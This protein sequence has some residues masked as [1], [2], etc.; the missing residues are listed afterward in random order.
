MLTKDKLIGVRDQNGIRPLC[1]GTIGNSYVIASES[2]A[3]DA[4]GAD[5]LRD[6][7]PGEIVIID[8]NGL[9]SINFA[10]K[11]KNA[12]CSFEYIYFARPDSTIDGIN[13]YTSRVAAGEQLFKESPVDADMV[14]GV[15]DSGTGCSNRIF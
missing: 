1:I 3:L 7:K 4:V 8:E 9:T 2:C 13:V 10:E 5:F 6:V 14:I 11:T 15:P 12:T